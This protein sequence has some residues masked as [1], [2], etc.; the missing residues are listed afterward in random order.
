MD[1]SDRA[2][3]YVSICPEIHCGMMV[4]Q[5]DYWQPSVR[6]VAIVQVVFS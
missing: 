6:M 1:S 3:R 2:A 5:G 4:I